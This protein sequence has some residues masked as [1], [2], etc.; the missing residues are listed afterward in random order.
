MMNERKPC[1][2]SYTIQNN[3]HLGSVQGFSSTISFLDQNNNYVLSIVVVVVVVVVQ[4]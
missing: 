2:V 3:T 4:S 1:V